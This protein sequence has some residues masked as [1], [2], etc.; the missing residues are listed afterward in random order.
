[1]QRRITPALRRSLGVTAALALGLGLAACSTGSD[2]DGGSTVELDINIVHPAT[3]DIYLTLE[4]VGDRIEE[5]TDGRVTVSIFP[6]S[7]LGSNEDTIEQFLTGAPTV[8]HFNASNA[9]TM[10]KVPE[11]LALGMAYVVPSADVIEP[12]VASDLYADWTERLEA[13]DFVVLS[14]NWLNGARQIISTDPNGHVTPDDLAGVTIRIPGGDQYSTFFNA[15]PALPVNLDASETYTGLEQGT[16]DAAEGPLRQM[17]DWS[18]DELGK[19][20]TM[21]NHMIEI[22]GF[23]MGGTTWAQISEDDQKIVREEFAQGGRDYT[24]L[25]LSSADA[26]RA[27]MEAEGIA[28]YEVDAD[29]YQK[30]AKDAIENS[31]AAAEWPADLLD[32]LRQA[33]GLD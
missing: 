1:M 12:F 32:Q 21:T 29:A 27:E 9:A 7:Q 17:I 14:G 23:A 6:D 25:A 19:S 5:R 30:L 2:G 15:T 13:N 8:A 16:V 18:L 22:T 11:Y 28:F 24:A 20:V 3:S 33:M 4:E 26:L 31:A 10:G